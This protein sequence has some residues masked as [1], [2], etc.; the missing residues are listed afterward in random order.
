MP[1]F[2]NTDC[3][4]SLIE[5]PGAAPDAARTLRDAVDEATCPLSGVLAAH[6]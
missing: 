2:R 6:Q 3:Y 5:E 1:T 4:A